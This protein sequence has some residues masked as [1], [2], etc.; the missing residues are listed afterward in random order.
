MKIVGIATCARITDYLLPYFF[1]T[2]SL[3]DT[4]AFFLLK[5]YTLYSFPVIYITYTRIDI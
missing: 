2:D 5:F 4:M 1:C 3:M